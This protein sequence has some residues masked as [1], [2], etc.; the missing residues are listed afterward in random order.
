MC[1]RRTA[2]GGSCTFDRHCD[3]GSVNCAD[4][5]SVVQWRV[6]HSQPVLLFEMVHVVL[7]SMLDGARRLMLRLRHSP[8]FSTGILPGSTEA[9]GGAVSLRRH[10][11]GRDNATGIIEA[12]RE[13]VKG[14]ESRACENEE[15]DALWRPG[16]LHMLACLGLDGVVSHTPPV[17]LL[18]RSI[19]SASK[20][21][22][23]EEI[24]A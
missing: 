21:L 15:V 20:M 10:Q 1:N 7:W 17:Q 2:V 8:S 3:I 4:G 5:G 19:V 13:G 12:C 23:P 24:H 22:F 6:R 18:M 16:I 9:R 11:C 14:V